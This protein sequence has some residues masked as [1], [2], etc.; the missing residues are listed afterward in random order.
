[1]TAEKYMSDSAQ[2][3][4]AL[5]LSYYEKSEY[6][7]AAELLNSLV[8][9]DVVSPDILNFFGSSLFRLGDFSNAESL[10]RASLVLSPN[11]AQTYVHMAVFWRIANELDKSVSCYIKAN[12]L[13]P[14]DSQSLYNAALLLQEQEK[15]A[16]SEKLLDRFIASHGPEFEALLGKAVAKSALFDYTGGEKIFNALL[17]TKP[18]DETVQ[19]NLAMIYAKTKRGRDADVLFRKLISSGFKDAHFA[20][21]LYLFSEGEWGAA[22]KYY[23]ARPVVEELREFCAHHNV[24]QWDGVS[25]LSEKRVFVFAEQGLGDHIR[26]LFFLKRLALDSKY[27]TIVNDPRLFPIIRSI[28]PDFKCMARDEIS[29]EHLEQ[30]LDNVFLCI[31][32]LGK[33]Y[34]DELSLRSKAGPLPRSKASFLPVTSSR[35]SLPNEELVE[36]KPLVGVSWR[37]VKLIKERNDWYCTAQELASALKDIDAHIICLQYD[38]QEEEL[39]AFSSCGISLIQPCDINLKDDQLKLA[40]LMSGLDAVVSVSTALTELAGAVGVPTYTLAVSDIRWY[41]SEEHIHGFYPN[42]KVFYKE[43]FSIWNKALEGLSKVLTSDLAACLEN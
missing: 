33:I 24:L 32:S 2:S 39:A 4:L 42:T 25:S 29:V 17:K 20:Y 23:E 10:F 15:W 11:Y 1:M 37:S 31:G 26:Y 34:G 28:Y 13:D 8:R 43:K 27:V 30:H 41:M 14:S 18:D 21:S 12:E 40:Q 6:K 3:T 22:F 16:E 35:A 5:A 7:A 36:N 9:R 38:V 19:F